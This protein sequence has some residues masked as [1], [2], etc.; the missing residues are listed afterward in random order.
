MLNE[1]SSWY[2]LVTVTSDNKTFYLTSLSP[3]LPFVVYKS[4]AL[5]KNL[6]GL[7]E[8]LFLSG[9]CIDT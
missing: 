2:I 7:I 6:P 8:S 9:I 1:R 3:T 4:L 5:S